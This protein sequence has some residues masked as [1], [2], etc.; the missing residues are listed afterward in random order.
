MGRSSNVGNH[1]TIVDVLRAQAARSPGKGYVCLDAPDGA[2]ARLTF[3]ELDRRALA[4]ARWL[5]EMGI[6][7]GT[8]VLLAYPQRLEFVIALFG[9]IYAGIPPVPVAPPE[10]HRLGRSLSR[11][12]DIIEASRAPLLLTSADH[13]AEIRTGLGDPVLRIATTDALDPGDPSRTF[14][15]DLRADDVAFVQFSSGSTTTPQ[16]I[17]VRHSNLLAN[18]EHI[19]RGL[20][21]H[22][23]T[24]MLNWVPFFH[25]MGLVGGIFN[26][27]ALPMGGYVMSPLTLMHRPLSWLHAIS[28]LGVTLSSGPNFAY[29]LCVRRT[30]PEQ[31]ATLDLSR[32]ERSVCGAEPIGYH[33]MRRFEEA[34][35]PAGLRRGLVVPCYGLAEATLYASGRPVGM[36]ISAAH[37]DKDQ[38]GRNLAVEVE[39]SA[40]NAATFVGCGLPADGTRIFIADPDSRQELEDGHIGEIWIAGPHV[41]LGYWNMPEKTAETFEARLA[42]GRGPFLRTGDLGFMRGGEIF[43]TGRR[44]DLI[45]IG[46]RNYYPQDIEWTAERAHPSVRPGCVAAFSVAGDRGEELAVVVE[47]ERGVLGRAPQDESRPAAEAPDGFPASDMLGAVTAAVGHDHGLRIGA[48]LLVR[49]GAV[50]K[51]TSGKVR[52][53]ACR[54]AMAAGTLPV[55]ARYPQQGH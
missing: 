24:V 23:G 30:T 10:P 54:A 18:L 19:H 33:T 46:G 35:E 50:P 28:E 51:T 20:D 9:C 29:E 1:R 49:P 34:F 3:V 44:K 41:A 47:V 40:A 13:V 4:V 37:L 5:R 26:I 11:L 22:D 2:L 8:P 7:K 16:G 31:R 52:R 6:A 38:L 17:A 15:P 43:V 55:L 12:R 32:W 45:I 48:L 27:A 39:E 42:D 14:E 53:S 21:V 36:G 25:D